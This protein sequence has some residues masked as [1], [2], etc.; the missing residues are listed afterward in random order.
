ML[1]QKHEYMYLRNECHYSEIYQVKTT[2]RITFFCKTDILVKNE[3]FQKC[4]K[5]ENFNQNQND[6][7]FSETEFL[8]T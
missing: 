8:T 3:N 2:L 4:E 7:F 1:I 6:H 5:R